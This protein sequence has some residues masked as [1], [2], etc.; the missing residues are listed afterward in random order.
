MGD[1]I[2]TDKILGKLD[3]YKNNPDLWSAYEHILSQ[4]KKIEGL[5]SA[6][7]TLSE[8]QWDHVAT[9]TSRIAELEEKLADSSNA[10]KAAKNG[11][12]LITSL[13]TKLKASQSALE[14]ARQGFTDVRDSMHE[15]ISES[16]NKANDW[17]GKLY[18][19]NPS[20]IIYE[21]R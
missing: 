6:M 10:T 3:K 13:Q 17:V 7:D 15:E 18:N 2:T 19:P 21:S 14:D 20:S 4:Q 9:L 5:E 11:I 12:A 8:A 16:W 1:E